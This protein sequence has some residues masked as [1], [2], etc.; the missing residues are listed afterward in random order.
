MQELTAFVKQ[1]LA[2]VADPEKAVHMAAYMKTDMPFYGVQSGPRREIARQ[3][4]LSKA[5]RP[6]RMLSSNCGGYR[7]V[8]RNTSLSLWQGSTGGLSALNRFGSMKS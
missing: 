3:A 6:M 7:I 2:S 1:K 4:K 8:R 5:G